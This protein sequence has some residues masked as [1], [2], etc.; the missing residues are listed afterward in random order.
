MAAPLE[1]YTSVDLGASEEATP[2]QT[3]EKYFWAIFSAA[4]LTGLVQS[5]L[6]GTP[7]Y[8]YRRVAF[9]VAFIAFGATVVSTVI[10]I[11]RA[12]RPARRQT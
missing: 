1:N 2:R 10:R 7:L 6:Y 11:V 12:R 9:T 8:P 4:L 3:P 5:L